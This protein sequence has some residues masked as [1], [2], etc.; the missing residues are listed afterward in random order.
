MPALTEQQAEAYLCSYQCGRTF[1]IIIVDTRTGTSEQ[2]CLPD[3]LM[4]ANSMAE[5]IQ[6]G[7]VGGEDPDAPVPYTLA[8]DTMDEFDAS[9][10]FNVAISEGSG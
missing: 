5:A 6:T 10:P 1:D 4:L 2:L 9:V 8:D 3:F 7:I